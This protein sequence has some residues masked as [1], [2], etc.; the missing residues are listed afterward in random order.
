MT[1]KMKPISIYIDGKK[2]SYTPPNNLVASLLSPG[3]GEP[4]RQIG[5]AIDYAWERYGYGALL[6]PTGKTKIGELVVFY[7]TTIAAVITFALTVYSGYIEG[8]ED[9]RKV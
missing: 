4:Q 3:Y 6:P 2:T 5:A 7:D 8:K 1:A 9:N